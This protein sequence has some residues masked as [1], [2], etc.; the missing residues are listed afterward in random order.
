[1]AVSETCRGREAGAV[2]YARQFA[3]LLETG[4][5]MSGRPGNDI[6]VALAYIGE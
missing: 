4:P 6:I 1:M 3:F 2:A 5:E